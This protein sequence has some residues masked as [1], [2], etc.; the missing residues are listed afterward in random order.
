MEDKEMLY[1]AAQAAGFSVRYVEAFTRYNYTGY[2]RLTKEHHNNGYPV[3][4]RW[5]PINSN[6][7]AFELAVLLRISTVFSGKN[8][9]QVRQGLPGFDICAEIAGKDPWSV[10]RYAIVREASNLP[11][12]EL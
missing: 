2:L 7:D 12:M 3:W 6:A 1:K 11:P 8:R 4:I 10:V 5:D 9:F